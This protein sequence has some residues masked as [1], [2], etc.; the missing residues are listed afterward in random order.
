MV[1]AAGRGNLELVR[2]LISHGAKCD[3]G[4]KYG[5]TPLIWACRAGHASVVEE[6]LDQGAQ[7][8]FFKIL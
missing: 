6:L 3:L 7:V 5:T 2:L 1:W 8:R 4:D